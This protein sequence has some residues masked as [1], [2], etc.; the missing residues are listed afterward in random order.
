MGMSSVARAQA[1]PMGYGMPKVGLFYNTTATDQIWERCAKVAQEVLASAGIP[2][3]MHPIYST[4]TADDIRYQLSTGGYTAVIG[5]NV[6]ASATKLADGMR[7]Y[8]APL[9]YLEAVAT[10]DDL[11]PLYQGS[12]Y[13][14]PPTYFHRVAVTSS[15]WGMALAQEFQS[16]LGGMPGNV[17]F[18]LRSTTAN[19]NPS[20]QD[21]LDPFGS[22]AKLG[23][24]SQLGAVSTLI[25]TN[26]TGTQFK[27]GNSA[28]NVSAVP[29][30]SGTWVIGSAL[31]S[32]NAVNV[33]LAT[34]TANA[35]GTLYLGVIGTVNSQ[36]SANAD[37]LAF[38][39]TNGIGVIAHHPGNPSYLGY[40]GWSTWGFRNPFTGALYDNVADINAIDHRLMRA[41]DAAWLLAS[42]MLNSHD[43]SSTYDLMD[44]FSGAPGEYLYPSKESLGTVSKRP[45][46]FAL[47][48]EGASGPIDFVDGE[49]STSWYRVWVSFAGNYPRNFSGSSQ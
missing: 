2:A 23:F 20:G 19:L 40:A 1:A 34:K 30:V 48:F 49:C 16:S 4:T 10:G 45:D 27:L 13:S 17:A 39:K 6:S 46:L 33:V 24:D 41:L 28:G 18:I 26:T 7:L 44:Q 12:A 38:M 29:P 5:A 42:V 15:Q 32:T 43:M 3:F 21:P 14:M 9:Q 35:G 36:I 37:A 11:N 25:V 22:Q 47:N 31:D 8:G